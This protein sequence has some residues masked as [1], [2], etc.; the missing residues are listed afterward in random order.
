MEPFFKHISDIHFSLHSVIVRQSEG[1]DFDLKKLFYRWISVRNENEDYHDIDWISSPIS[2][3]DLPDDILWSDII[4]YAEG[5]PCKR[6][7]LSQTENDERKILRMDTAELLF[8]RFLHE[9]LSP[10]QREWVEQIWNQTFNSFVPVDYESFDYTLE[11]FSGKYDGKKF[12]LHE[13]QKKGFAFLCSKGN[14]LLAYDVG[15]G[16]TATGIAA[17]IYQLQHQKCTRPLIIVPKH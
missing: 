17:V 14:G 4:D 11:S 2:K 12:I 15:V 6:R 1:T 9:G 7:S 5:L 10:E 16:K 3:T 13:Q 8:E